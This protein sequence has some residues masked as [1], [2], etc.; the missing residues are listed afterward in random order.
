MEDLDIFHT[1][2]QYRCENKL[3]VVSNQHHALRKKR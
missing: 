3:E 2:Q 1:I